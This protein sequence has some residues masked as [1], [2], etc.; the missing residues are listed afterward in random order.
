MNRL[1]AQCLFACLLMLS[2]TALVSH[3]VKHL[4][5]GHNEFCAAYA[6]QDHHSNI[7]AVGASQ[8]FDNPH[9]G[10]RSDCVDLLELTSSSVYASRAPPS[11]VFFS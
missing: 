10:F 5:S 6:S 2:Q 9:Q 1:F 8:T 11:A 3:D 7:I 4:D